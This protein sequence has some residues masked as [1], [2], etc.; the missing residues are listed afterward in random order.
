MSY[1]SK[2][3]SEQIESILD[4]VMRKD[5]TEEYTPT[6]D[7]NPATKKYVEENK[8][9]Q[10]KVVELSNTDLTAGGLQGAENAEKRKDLLDFIKDPVNNQI[11]ISL[12]D[13]NVRFVPTLER[14]D[15]DHYNIN[16]V[17]NYTGEMDSYGFIAIKS[18]CIRFEDSSGEGFASPD[19]A[20]ILF[21]KE[22]D[23]S[24]AILFPPLDIDTL[25][26]LTHLH[27]TVNDHNDFL[28]S[29][30]I[31]IHLYLPSDHYKDTDFQYYIRVSVDNE[32]FFE[33]GIEFGGE[34]F[35]NK[36]Y[37]SEDQNALKQIKFKLS[38][39]LVNETDYTY[40]LSEES[41]KTI[42]KTLTQTEYTSLGDSVNTD[43]A[44]Y[45][46]KPDPQS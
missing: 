38:R 35:F 19:S 39:V 10:I 3:T 4:N 26:P 40:I 37:F 25:Q 43:G 28:V 41:L 42:T 36:V 15:Q 18:I 31:T 44:L 46:V 14:V 23:L 8:G 33:S 13:K 27:Q 21:A 17:Y 12:T 45:F 11:V 34:I 22:S 6:G 32:E 1:K 30:G 24:N 5:N 2:F 29:N 7:Y 9:A 20:M 16:G